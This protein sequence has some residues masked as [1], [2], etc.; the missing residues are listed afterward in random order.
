MDTLIDLEWS[1]KEATKP[2]KATL[3]YERLFF[4]ETDGSSFPNGGLRQTHTAAAFTSW[5]RSIVEAHAI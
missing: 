3:P 2:F 5:D 1:S 4:G